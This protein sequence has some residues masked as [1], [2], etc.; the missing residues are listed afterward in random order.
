MFLF[1][2]F[3]VFNIEVKKSYFELIEGVI[4]YILFFKVYWKYIHW[5]TDVYH[6]K[7]KM[8]YTKDEI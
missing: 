8:Y 1:V 3:Y 2:C 4:A 5:E 6:L 7:Y